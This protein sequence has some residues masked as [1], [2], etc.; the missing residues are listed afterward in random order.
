MFSV[1]ANFD[2][3]DAKK[4]LRTY[5][6]S[7]LFGTVPYGTQRVRY[8]T[9]HLP[10]CRCAYWYLYNY[11]LQRLDHRDHFFIFDRE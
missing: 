11:Y 10:V 6:R 3:S 9:V 8:G 2:S 4:A 5:T 7:Q 1:H